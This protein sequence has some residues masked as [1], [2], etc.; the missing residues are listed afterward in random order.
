MR[1]GE[2]AHAE[3][4]ASGSPVSR[5]KMMSQDP[6]HPITPEQ[7]EEQKHQKAEQQIEGKRRAFLLEDPMVAQTNYVIAS[8]RPIFTKKYPGEDFIR[9]CKRMVAQGIVSQE[10]MDAY[11]N[12]LA[13]A[14]E[15]YP[16]AK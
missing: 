11:L 13:A 1:R 14:E 12:R 2:F 9:L 16:D 6:D 4:M 15:L 7:R 5:E 8:A 10:K 3:R